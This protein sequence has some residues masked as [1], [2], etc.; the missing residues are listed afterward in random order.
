MNTSEKPKLTYLK[1]IKVEPFGGTVE[2][3]NYENGLVVKLRVLTFT[4][5][6]ANEFVI[7]AKQLYNE[8]KNYFENKE[9]K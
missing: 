8:L 7:D 9:N 6:E 2:L 5:L 4:G 1:D 3:Q